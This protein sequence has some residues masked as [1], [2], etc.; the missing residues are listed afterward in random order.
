MS[1]R[2][3]IQSFFF[4]AGTDACY[5]I[6]IIDIAKEITNSKNIIEQEALI[7]GIEKK[8]IEFHEKNYSDIR[9]FIVLDAGAYLSYLTGSKWEC[10][11]TGPEYTCK[12]G[13][14]EILFWA[15][16]AQRSNEGLGHFTRP[17]KNTLQFSKNVAEGQVY[18]KRIF[19]KIN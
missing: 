12:P 2:D 7:A 6:C 19:K 18:Q 4:T 13:E 8:Y 10:I 16:T 15:T 3:H 11:K 14:Y 9:N 17:G 5:A 1:V